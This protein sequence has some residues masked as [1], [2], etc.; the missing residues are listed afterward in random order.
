M[1]HN[2][3]TSSCTH[4]PLQVYDDAEKI[5]AH[6]AEEGKQ[7][8]LDALQVVHPKSIPL[9]VA[10][11]TNIASDI[12]QGQVFAF[13]TVHSARREIVPVDLGDNAL[14]SYLQKDVV[15][16][17]RDGKTGYVLAEHSGAGLAPVVSRF[18]AGTGAYASQTGSGD[19]VL[20][21]ANIELTISGGRITSFYDVKLERELIPEGKTG[22]LVIF[23]DRYVKLNSPAVRF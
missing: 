10:P 20:K 23:T 8:I 19:F 17:S 7:I 11:G 21:N 22:G 13:N 15:Q 4:G 1:I 3:K 18:A 6:I 9:P 5:Y 2:S 16:V 14:T 12:S